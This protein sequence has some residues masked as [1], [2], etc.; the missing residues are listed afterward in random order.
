MMWQQWFTH[1]RN[2]VLVAPK[3][4]HII[5][6]TG[7]FDTIHHPPHSIPSRGHPSGESQKAPLVTCAFGR[8]NTVAVTRV[9]TKNEMFDQLEQ[10]RVWRRCSCWWRWHQSGNWQQ[11]F[12]IAIAVCVRVS[13]HPLPRCGVL[14]SIPSAKCQNG[15][16]GPWRGLC[17]GI[18][19]SNQKRFY[20]PIG[21]VA[22]VHWTTKRPL[23][24]P[25]PTLPSPN[26]NRLAI[27]S[28]PVSMPEE[29]ICATCVS[30]RVNRK[31]P[32]T[33]ICVAMLF[34]VVCC[35]CSHSSVCLT[36]NPVN[37]IDWIR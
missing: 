26:Q 6:H 21:C 32:H 33:N 7:L 5:G 30:T 34:I 19:H 2:E 11:Q 37:K 31:M 18:A 36:D 27:Q 9:H 4:H 20:L 12:S 16:Y 29:K 24:P 17:Y 3:R 25:L 14:K 8:S 13:H 23:S 22:T 28:Y 15:I 35:W 10:V 1:I